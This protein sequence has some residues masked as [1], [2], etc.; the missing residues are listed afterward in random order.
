M[1]KSNALISSIRET[2]VLPAEW[3]D[4]WLTALRNTIWKGLSDSEVM[5]NAAFC[6]QY[7]LNPF[8][9]EMHV[10]KGNPFVGRDG[11][12]TTAERHPRYQ[13][14]VVG[15]VYEFD[16]FSV[17]DGIAHHTVNGF[18]DRGTYLGAYCTV[19]TKSGNAQTFTRKPSDFKHLLT[20]DNW[21]KDLEGMVLIR[22]M[23]W[24]F[25]SIFSLGNLYTVEEAPEVLDGSIVETDH[26]ADMAAA[27]LEEIA[28]ELGGSPEDE[29]Q[30]DINTTDLGDGN[31]DP[32]A[33]PLTA[34]TQFDRFIAERGLP[35]DK[36]YSELIDVAK[37]RDKRGIKDRDYQ[38][39]LDDPES[40]IT[41]VMGQ[42][43]L[44]I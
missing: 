21:K 11:F 32:A 5:V 16:D 22:T 1:S 25:R 15:Q 41:L 12:L 43:E 36:A 31:G 38:A 34:K 30:Q 40:F 3:N 10:I 4:R 18:G 8:L 19:Y 7:K 24:G 13:D 6:G 9:K 35:Y 26:Q 23:T 39:A 2:G 33:A 27:R 28:A 42:P 14:H 29:Q 37:A 20:K 44:G 17:T